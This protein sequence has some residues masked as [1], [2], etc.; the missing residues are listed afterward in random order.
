MMGLWSRPIRARALQHL[1]TS[2][3]EATSLTS[4]LYR[5][6]TFWNLLLDDH[7][8]ELTGDA[9][10]RVLS[11]VP[12]DKAAPQ[13]FGHV[14]ILKLAHGI[15]SQLARYEV[16]VKAVDFAFERPV[17]DED[18]ALV[19]PAPVTAI[20]FDTSVLGPVQF[21]STQ[22]LH[23]SRKRAPRMYLHAIARTHTI[24]ACPRLSE[25]I[26]MGRGASRRRG[27]CLAHDPADL[28]P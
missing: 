10:T 22:D 5:F 8:F 23:R 24:L 25:P 13:R 2:I 19:F 12:T 9:D 26:H 7:Q 3:R 18:Y 20:H 4:A 28:D 11:L 15:L 27:A 17:F 1:L 21:R 16:A 6:S 14:L